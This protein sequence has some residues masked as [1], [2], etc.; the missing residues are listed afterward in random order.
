[1]IFF[2]KENNKKESFNLVKIAALMIH[3][4]KID[5]KYSNDEEEI[6]KKTL[7]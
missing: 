2:K 7:L 1:M 3:A 6:I 4:A 5:E